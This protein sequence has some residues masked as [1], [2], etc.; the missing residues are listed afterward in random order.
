M[1]L[2]NVISFF[3]PFLSPSFLI[4]IPWNLG[5]G[6]GGGWGGRALGEKENC[7]LVKINK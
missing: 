4:H 3:F 2:I 6:F 7:L 1:R 5:N